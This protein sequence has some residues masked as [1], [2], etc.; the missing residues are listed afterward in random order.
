MQK[1]KVQEALIIGG[2]IIVSNFDWYRIFRTTYFQ[3][4]IFF[5][6]DN[7]FLITINFYVA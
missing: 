6:V 4:A 5:A 2:F 3:F 7:Y 1:L